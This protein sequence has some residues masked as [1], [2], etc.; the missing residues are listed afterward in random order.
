LVLER[1]EARAKA[2]DE[3][4]RQLTMDRDQRSKAKQEA[5]EVLVM[6]ST[7]L[8]AA[9]ADV[10]AMLVLSGK[11]VG[12][13]KV[14]TDKVE[15]AVKSG[16]INAKQAMGVINRWAKVIEMGVGA[17]DRLIEAERRH[18]GEPTEVIEHRVDAAE[19]VSVGEA[20]KEL[21]EIREML[22]YAQENG[23]S[24][25]SDDDDAPEENVVN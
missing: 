3:Q 6:E 22:S 14:L 5:I 24:L 18:K 16:E 17:T 9:R 7:L 19:P 2:L 12:S 13:M 1:S 10:Q 4:E 11:L 15:E 20:L 25:D 21:E 23:I 8:K